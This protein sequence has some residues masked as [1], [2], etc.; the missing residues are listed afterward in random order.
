MHVVGQYQSAQRHDLRGEE[1]RPHQQRQVDPNESGPG[2]RALAFWSRRQAVALQD[3]ADRLIADLVPQIGQRPHNSVIA[4]ITV[5]PGHAN[6][7]LLNFSLDSRP[8]GASTRLRAIEF[9]GDQL[10]V[11]D[12]DGVR[13]ATLASSARTLRPNR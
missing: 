12:Q 13:R 9:A 1:V 8:A 11:P 4:P 10:A 3:I 2:C 7:Q 5:L 6:D